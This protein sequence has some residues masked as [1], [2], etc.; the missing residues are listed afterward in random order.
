[1]ETKE[2]S[3][4]LEAYTA[5]RDVRKTL[6]PSGLGKRSS[7]NPAQRRFVV[8][9]H[10]AQYLHYDLRVEADGLSKYWPVPKGA[11]LKLGEKRLAIQVEEHPPSYA[12]FEGT[13][14]EGNYGA[15]TVEIWDE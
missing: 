8:Q 15:G 2:N 11:P 7:S 4:H 3:K 9:R 13:I 1:M 14:P 10:D 12:S 6:E 5:K